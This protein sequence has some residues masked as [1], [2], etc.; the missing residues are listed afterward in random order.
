MGI[1]LS[2]GG[3]IENHLTDLL[4]SLSEEDHN[5]LL[6]VPNEAQLPNAWN[7]T[8]LSRYLNLCPPALVRKELN[9]FLESMRHRLERDFKRILQYHTSMREESIKKLVQFEQMK[10]LSERQQSE[11]KR[12]HQRL[13]SILR[14]YRSK[15]QDIEQKYEIDIECGIEQIL[16]LVIPVHR[17]E[18]MLLRRKG[19]RMLSLDWNPIIRKLDQPACEYGYSQTPNRIICDDHLHI[20][21]PEGNMLCPRCGKSYCRACCPTHCPKCKEKTSIL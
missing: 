15:V 9:F 19:T 4:K 7:K 16:E 1:N 12:S 20:T 2:N 8:E 17:L 18:F 13:D 11:Q 6:S 21:A 3:L 5:F 10:K 14:E